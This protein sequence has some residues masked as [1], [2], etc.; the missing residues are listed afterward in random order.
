MNT[1]PLKKFLLPSVLMFMVVFSALNL[2]FPAQKDNLLLAKVLFMGNRELKPT[3]L[4][5]RGNLM[6][7]YVGFTV[8]VSVGASIATV[9]AIRRLQKWN[10]AKQAKKMQALQMQAAALNLAE[11]LQADQETDFQHS[12]FDLVG[13]LEPGCETNEFSSAENFSATYPEWNHHDLPCSTQTQ[14]ME[15]YSHYQI[16]QIR[17]PYLEQSLSAIFADGFY[18]RF[19]KAEKT[20]DKAFNFVANLAQRGEHAVITCIKNGYAIWVWEP[21]ASPD[22]VA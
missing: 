7:R 13:N 2:S 1:S 8:I 14:P 15:V 16:C 6:I 17:V 11:S 22:L 18:Y 20:K 19:V 10:E 5:V 4:G 9:E 3:S 21:N 12:Q